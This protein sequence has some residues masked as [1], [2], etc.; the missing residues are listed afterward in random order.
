MIRSEQ[1]LREDKIDDEEQNDT[2]IR[3][4]TS[5]DSEAD[6]LGVARPSDAQGVGD[7]TG[8]AETE[9]QG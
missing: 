5:G 8:H 7:D 3:E 9:E 6:I 2:R 4:D 1:S